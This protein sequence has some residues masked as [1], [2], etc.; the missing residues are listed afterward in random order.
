MSKFLYLLKRLNFIITKE[1]YFVKF[2]YNW[3]ALPQRF[4]IINK[5]ILKKNY[6][7][8][9]EVGCFKNENF[10]QINITN[11]IGVD[12]V[13][14]GTLRMS[15]DEFFLKNKDQFDIIF[16][17]G[18]HVYEQVKRDIENSLIVLNEDGIILIHDCLPRKIWYQTDTRMSDT[19][20][21]D[22]WKAIVE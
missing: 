2:K 10:D 4:Q 8:Y 13:S 15:S 12:P 11:K 3:S 16:I 19:W 14:G 6:Q 5:I 20:N 9:L 22:V 18:L 21:G 17:D 1:R 7:N